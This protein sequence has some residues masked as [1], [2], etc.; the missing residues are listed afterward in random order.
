MYSSFLLFIVPSASSQYLR[1]L[2]HSAA[3]AG[4]EV[5]N[6][7]ISFHDDMLLYQQLNC[8]FGIPIRANIL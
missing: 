3:T 7:S 1:R 4:N 5:R 6:R 8:S 2:V